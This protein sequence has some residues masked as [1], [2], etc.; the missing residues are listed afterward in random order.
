MKACNSWSYCPYRPP[1]TEVG[2]IYVCRVVP[3]ETSIH[4]E[5]LDAAAESYSVFFRKRNEGEFVR[6]CDTKE[7][8]CDIEALECGND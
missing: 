7:T 4:F 6:Y 5:W 8:Y 3:A 1:L 2:D